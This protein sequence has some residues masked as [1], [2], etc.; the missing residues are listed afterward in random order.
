[1]RTWWLGACLVL[2]ASWSLEAGAQK[3]LRGKV[4]APEDHSGHNHAPGAHVG[5][6]TFDP[7]P[8]ATVMWKGSEVGA[9][10]D[11][12][13]FFQLDIRRNPDTLR[14]SM[15]GY[16]TVD[17]YF[18]GEDY[19]DIPLEPG[20]LLQ[21]ADVVFEERSQSV[22]LLNPL[23]I[24]QLSRKELCKA[25]CCN[26]SEAFET[27]ASVDASFTDA[28][29]GTRQIHMLGLAGKYTQLLVDNLPG[30]RGLNVVQ[31]MGFIPGPWIESIFISKGVGTVASGYESFTG[32]INV[33]HR[34]AETAEP[35]HLNLFYGGSGRMEFNHVSKH[36]VGRRWDTVLMTHGEYG[37]RENDRNQDG[38]LDT[39]L[40]QDGVVRNEW[41]FIG[42][43]GMRANIS[44]M[45]VDME[46]KG[47]MVPGDIVATPWVATTEIQRAEVNAK[48]G[49]VLPGQEGR[50]WGSQWTAS[51]HRH[52]HGFGNRYY[53]GQQNTFRANVLRSGFLGSEDRQF[54]AGVSYLYDDFLERGTWGA[55]PIEVEANPEKWARTEH[56]PGAFLETTWTG[57]PRGMVVAGLRVDQHNLWGTMVTPRLHARWSAT[58]QTSL[59]MVAGTGFR[60]P[61][62]LMEELGVWASNRTWIVDGP[63]EPERGWNAGF[64]V[65]SK[66]KLGYRDADFALDG[67]WTEFQNR[68]VVDLDADA[69]AVRIYNLGDRES[70][71]VTAQ[72][73][74]GWSVHRR[75]DMRLAYRYVHAT[76]Q[77]DGA[78]AQGTLVDPYVP[79]HRAFTQWSYSSKANDRGASWMGDLTM[80]W[81]GPQRIPRPDAD[82]DD[83]P[84]SDF[85][86]DFVVVNGQISRVFAPG[87]DLYLG[88]ENILNY[89][90]Q[91]PIVAAQLAYEDEQMFQEN[92]DASLVYGP[93]FGRMVYVGGRLT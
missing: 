43:R 3:S 74:L 62:V 93:I 44:V 84:A 39:P 45:G 15:V 89:R 56:V 54:S 67:Y 2:L 52:W 33:A 1:M 81:V 86:D 57:H 4:F 21:S 17:V 85:E 92:M 19:L 77:R 10:T 24:Q 7:L 6:E 61:N 80:Q 29:T 25:A 18:S 31:G 11:A 38:F 46:R 30:P 40:R 68:A 76:T 28:V 91:N 78:E 12:F 13:G 8:G 49:Y 14:V 48:V 27:N 20:V 70:R 41:R 50:S 55:A 35:F 65:T 59:K 88:V 60:T 73:E 63:L 82:F 69:H 23:N 71:S 36:K 51:T 53:D 37:Q 47:G 87:I 66:F 22:S 32:Q 72:A 42:D 64:N 34:N 83:R 26:L 5:K 75:V 79:Q 90:Q 9:V 16:Q 58:E